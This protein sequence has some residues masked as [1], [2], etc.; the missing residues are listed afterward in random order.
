MSR[1]HNNRSR[2]KLI[3]QAVA[4]LATLAC[5]DPAAAE[6]VEVAPGV[7]VTKRTYSAPPN[8]QPFFGFVVKSSEQRAADEDFV[9]AMIQAVGTREKAYEEASKRGWR[10]VTKGNAGEAAQRF[11]QAFL[12]A[13][14]QSGVYHGFAVIAQMRFRDVDFADELFRV[15]RKQPNPLKSLNADYGKVLLIAKRPREAQA[16]LEQA[17]KDAPDFRDAWTNLAW[18]RLQNGD[19]VAACAAADEAV[20]QRPSGNS[21]TDLTALRSSAQCK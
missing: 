13:P 2:F 6:T 19:P 5:V 7:Q 9:K 18:T 17:V 12:L 8:E 14:E 1:L 11:N 16:V 3:F 15:A 21:N 10:A 20:K 4:M